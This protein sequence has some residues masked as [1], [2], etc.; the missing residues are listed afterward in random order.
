MLYS[1]LNAVRSSTVPQHCCMILSFLNTVRTLCVISSMPVYFKRQD[2]VGDSIYVMVQCC[3]MLHMLAMRDGLTSTTYLSHTSTV[4]SRRPIRI[5]PVCKCMSVTTGGSPI[6]G[7]ARKSIAIILDVIV[8]ALAAA[9]LID[10][11]LLMLLLTNM[12][13]PASLAKTHTDLFR[14]RNLVRECYELATCM[15]ARKD[16]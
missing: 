6:C 5:I 10:H 13:L 16:P 8:L 14:G 1:A 15:L 2:R 3:S 11:V 4:N 7:R 12:L 9:S